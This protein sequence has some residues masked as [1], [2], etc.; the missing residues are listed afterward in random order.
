MKN[1]DTEDTVLEAVVASN[2][3]VAD[4]LSKSS[5]AAA[6]KE[7]IGQNVS[8][9][10]GLGVVLDYR[11]K[12][13]MFVIKLNSQDSYATM[14]LLYTQQIPIP[15]QTQ[16][17]LADELNVAMEALEKMRRLNL[18]VLCHEHGIN[19]EIDYDCCTTCLLSH[20]YEQSH[21]PRLQKLVDSAATA[22]LENFPRLQRFF[23]AGHNGTNNVDNAGNCSTQERRDVDRPSNHASNAPASTPSVEQTMPTSTNS[24]ADGESASFPR[25]KS[26]WGTIQSIPQPVAPSASSNSSPPN[27]A[28]VA[29]SSQN[30]QK[31]SASKRFP[32]IRGLL[33]SSGATEMLHSMT[34]NA[35][36]ATSGTSTKLLYN[37]S[38]RGKPKALP[39]IQ[40]LI[41][42]HHRANT[43]P[44]LICA[45][46]SCPAHSSASFRKEGITLCL[47][48][49]K[50]FELSF[51]VDCVSAP[52]P[53]ERARFI[54]HLVDC[55]DRCI[56]LLKYSSQFVEQIANTLKEQKE[57][58]N[59]IGLA[60]S[61]VGMFSGVLGI[62][63][64]ASI[65]TPAGPPLLIASLFF[66][67]GA[68]TVQTGSEAMNHFSEP[69]KLADK[70]IA[71]HGMALSILRV[72][73]TLR[74]AMMRDHIRT[75]VYVAEPTPLKEQVQEKI[76]KNRTAVLAGTNVGRS[77]ALSGVA[78]VEAGAGAGVVAASAAGV[79][80]SAGAG[81]VAGATGARSATAFSRAGTAAA[82]TV[83]FAR[84]AGG[85][86]SA[87]VLVLEA[88][89][90]QSTLKSIHDGN[91]CEKADTLH[92]VAMEIKDFPTST[93][94]DEECQ[95]YLEVLATRPPPSVAEVC[96]VPDDSHAQNIPEADCQEVDDQYQLCAPGAVVVDG[97]SGVCSDAFHD[98][99]Q[100]AATATSTSSLMGGSS[101]IQRFQ[102]RQEHRQNMAMSRTEEV[103]AVA[104]DDDQRLQDS[105]INLVV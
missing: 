10:L 101:L 98:Q 94:L 50:L 54:D 32:R 7:L 27:T 6:A 37:D 45:S 60:S 35:A 105:Q 104:V 28:S 87:A 90:I 80:A 49:E 64:A 91:Q 96:A 57:R 51:I 40:K 16:T 95:A 11:S 26:L 100:P 2:G 76:E 14:A 30:S 85:A 46:P 18:E 102:E 58:Q 19:G 22:D 12:D 69:R 83:R 8:T 61:S 75:D 79:E 47:E 39:R 48:C 44:C 41:D 99:G 93:E 71:L 34:A 24:S 56:L 88:N 70:I 66:G 38:E 78:G 31:E 33:D 84:F 3:A 21:F 55:Y 29:S 4:E 1:K 5:D 43:F 72:T 74:D 92:R 68:T 53:N 9:S 62:A 86:L 82:R 89:A 52:D 36:P 103:I 42:Q 81:A 77:M 65:L 67:G 20:K 17:Q 25:L 15:Y 13:G 97:I 63:A 23:H 59:K 73:S